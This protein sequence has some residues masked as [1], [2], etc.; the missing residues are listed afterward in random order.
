MIGNIKID[1]SLAESMRKFQK[2]QEKEA[3]VSAPLRPIDLALPSCYIFDLDRTLAIKSPN[4]GIFEFEK[5]LD[6]T[7]VIAIQCLIQLLHF[8]IS[9]DE[10]GDTT[11]IIILTG[12]EEKFRDVVEKWLEKHNILFDQLLMRGTGDHRPADITKE[13]LYVYNIA[14]KYNVIFALEDDK[15]VVDMWRRLGIYCL[16]ADISRE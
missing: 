16:V 6:D 11:E 1:K 14:Y 13:D 4:R 2:Q 8:G 7:P 15:K 10:S 9:M 12:R 3:V 5:S